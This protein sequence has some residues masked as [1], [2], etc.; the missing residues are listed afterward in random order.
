[1]VPLQSTANFVLLPHLPDTI[2]WEAPVSACC[3]ISVFRSLDASAQLSAHRLPLT[4]DFT[5]QTDLAGPSVFE[6]RRSPTLKSQ[7]ADDSIAQGPSTLT[8]AAAVS[9]HGHDERE[10]DGDD[11]RSVDGDRH[12]GRDP[13][14]GRGIQSAASDRTESSARGN[15]PAPQTHGKAR[16]ADGPARGHCRPQGR[17]FFRHGALVLWCRRH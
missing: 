14:C 5:T 7:N 16:R 15:R 11:S 1:M 2:Y 3:S 13:H 8:R 10:D 4:H 6:P 9:S 17:L 12:R